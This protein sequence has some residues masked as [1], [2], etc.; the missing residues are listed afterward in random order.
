MKIIVNEVP[1]RSYECPFSKYVY[2]G[3]SC[4]LKK[5]TCDVDCKRECEMLMSAKELKAGE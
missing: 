2:G 1:K 5:D 3:Y 4:K